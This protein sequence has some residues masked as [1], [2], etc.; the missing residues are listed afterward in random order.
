MSE[1]SKKARKEMRDKIKR[2]TTDP[3]KK[4]DSSSWT[5][6]EPLNTEAKTGLRPISPRQYKRG[7]KVGMMAGGSPCAPRADRKARKAGGEVKEWVKAKINRDV[8]EANEERPGKKHVG[9]M[10]HGGRSEKQMGGPMGDP[11]MA[12][13]PKD[14]LNL[15]NRPPVYKKGGK[16]CKA[17]GGPTEGLTTQEIQERIRRVRPNTNPPHPSANTEGMAPRIV[18]D[19]TSTRRR[20]DMPPAQEPRTGRKAGG[21]I[22]KDK[23]LVKKAM[24]QHEKA[25]HGGKHSELKLKKGGK[26]DMSEGG[27]N[28]TGGTRPTGGRIARADGGLI[29]MNKGKGK[30]KKGKSGKGKT[31]ISIIIGT[32]RQGETTT[33][34]PI[35]AMGGPARPVPMPPPGMPPMPPG[36][37]PMPPGMPAAPPPGMPPMPPRMPM[38]APPGAPPGMPPGMPPMGRKDG[39]KVG[40]RTYRSYKDMD[41]GGLSGFGRLEK[42]E[43]QKHKRG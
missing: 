23:A 18:E 37:P 17:E 9:G 31:N 40:H 25:Q 8:K 1:M 14:R 34:S 10:K 28:Y 4:V 33:T 7:G 43:I 6:E 22:S 19:G 3:H 5:P 20:G 26:A 21:D 29:P 15:S 12:M 2:L 32:P 16:A 38:G 36:M 30:G 35:P 11:R 39:G 27:G 13:V 41:A 24:R 42:T